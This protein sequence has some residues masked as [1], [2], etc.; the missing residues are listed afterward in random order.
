MNTTE[1]ERLV[2]KMREVSTLPQQ[3]FGP[4][5]P[6]YRMMVPHF[7]QA[8]WRPLFFGTVIA[9]IVLYGVLGASVVVLASILQQNF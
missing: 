6:L 2:L 1:Y 3:T 5:T 9:S 4:L 7:K 8:L